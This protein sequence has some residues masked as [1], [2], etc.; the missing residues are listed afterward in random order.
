LLGATTTY[1]NFASG[2]YQL[3]A[4]LVRSF[5]WNRFPTKTIDDWI[6]L[7]RLSGDIVTWK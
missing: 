2:K 4:A 1:N 6:T 7:R 5:T 3:V